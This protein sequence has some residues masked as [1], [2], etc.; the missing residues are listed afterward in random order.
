MKYVCLFLL[1]ATCFCGKLAAGPNPGTLSLWYDRPAARWEEALP[2]GNGRLGVMVYGGCVREELQIN[3]ETIWAG[4]PHNNVNPAA[5][6]ALPEVRRL[7]FEGRYKEAFDLCDEN[8]SLHASH[9]MPYQTAGS[10]LL[11]FPGHRNVSDFYRDL[12]LATATATVGYAVDGIRYKREMF[13]SF[14]DQVAVVRL[15]AS[16]RRRISFRISFATPMQNYRVT[17]QGNDR[18]LIDGRTDGHETIP[19]QVEYRTVAEISPEGGTTVADSAGITVTG[20]DAVTILVS[21]A[22]NFNDYKDI[23]GDPVSRAEAYLTQAKKKSYKRLR[24]DHIAAYRPWIERVSLDLGVNAQA[25]KTTDA[26]VREF[27][28]HFDPQL[29]SLYFQFGR[30]LLICSSQPGGQAATLQGIWNHQTFPAW[31]SKYTININTEMNYWPAEAT[32]LSELHG[33]L[34][35]LI[36]DLSVTGRQAASGMYGARGWTAHHNT[37]IWRISGMVDT[38]LSGMWPTSNAWFCQHLWDRYLFSGDT[39]YLAEVYPVMKGACEFFLDFLTEEPEHGWLVCV[40]SISPENTPAKAGIHHAV[41]SGATMD[42]QMVFDLFSNTIAAAETLG[43]DADLAGELRE[44]RSRL[45]PMQ[46]GS[47]GQLQEWQQDWDNPEDRHRH[48]SHLWGLYPGRQISAYTT[49]D[50]FDAART[51]L[52]HRGDAS[53]GW[54]MGWKVCL[55]A[56]FLDGNHAYKLITDQISPEGESFESGGTYPNLFDAHPPFQIDGNFGCTAGIAEMLLQSHDGVIDLLPALPDVWRSGRVCG[57][58]ARGGFEIVRME[59]DGGRLTR[60][61][62]R[63]TIGGNCRVRSSSALRSCKGGGFRAAEG[64]NPNPLFALQ[65]I[66]PPVIA[67]GAPLHPVALPTKYTYDIETET[68]RVYTLSFAE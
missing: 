12:D 66:N 32:N 43:C 10:L 67:P 48:V 4:G 15:T 62:I 68:G 13:T 21:I 19:G 53:T 14:S 44:K 27:A 39:V 3:E 52:I 22:T 36:R 38:P 42:N 63:S 29:V 26:R 50:L 61:V 65:R 60:A 58:R 6:E 47:W 1:G 64:E 30:Y 11:D 2:L 23:S 49:P 9:G 31:D 37:D 18:L 41:V 40:P 28:T 5:R 51:S 8:F 56:R 34:I 46:V 55:W 35:D 20:A 57:L 24:A 59:W 45:A 25:A 16:E 7:I 17:T 54:S 33:P